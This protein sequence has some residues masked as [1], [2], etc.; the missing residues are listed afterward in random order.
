M[1]RNV[2]YV[3]GLYPAGTTERVHETTERDDDYAALHVGR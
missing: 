1:V 3:V 2:L